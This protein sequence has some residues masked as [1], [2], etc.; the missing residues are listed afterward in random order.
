MKHQFKSRQRGISFLGL[1]F[2][3]GILAVGGVIFAQAIPTFLEYQAI[4]KAA[5]KAA[6]GN[7]VVEVRQ[8]LC[9]QG[10]LGELVLQAL[11]KCSHPVVAG[12]A[13]NAVLVGT[14]LSSSFV[15]RLASH[16]PVQFDFQ[17]VIQVSPPARGVNEGFVIW[18]G[19][20]I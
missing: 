8:C 4:G 16:T 1:L 17:A 6:L 11:L 14:D 5:N 20:R 10:R 18:T 13:S 3:G 12:S 15:L 9:Q 19:P 2:V 7:S